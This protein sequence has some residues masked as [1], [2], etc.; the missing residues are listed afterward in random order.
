MKRHLLVSVLVAACMLLLAAGCAQLGP[1]ASDSPAGEDAGSQ[2]IVLTEDDTGGVIEIVA[3][4]QLSVRLPSNGTTGFGWVVADSGPLTQSGEAIYEEPQAQPG[5]VGA[6]GTETFTFSSSA[7]GS[8][9]LK[10]EYRRPWEKDVP[11][12]Q[13]WDVTVTVK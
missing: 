1:G 7:P 13:T 4:Q 6:G 3:G 2:L 12:E 8:G 11:A 5:L 9:Q 10:L